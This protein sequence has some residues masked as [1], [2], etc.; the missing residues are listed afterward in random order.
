MV[1]GASTHAPVA[2]NHTPSA[3]LFEVVEQEAFDGR[4]TD[5]QWQTVLLSPLGEASVLH[6]GKWELPSATMFRH[7]VTLQNRYAP[8]MQQRPLHMLMVRGRLPRLYA[9]CLGASANPRLTVTS[10]AGDDG[11]GEASVAQ[12]VLGHEFE[13]AARFEDK[14]LARLVRHKRQPVAIDGRRTELALR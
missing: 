11:A 3:E 2:A 4:E 14:H 13:F 5:V 8:A 6:E 9:H 1:S 12:V 7:R 10:S